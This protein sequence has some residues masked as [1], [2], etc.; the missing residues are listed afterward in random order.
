MQTVQYAVYMRLLEEK[1]PEKAGTC[2]HTV[3]THIHNTHAHIHTTHLA[4]TLTA[5]EIDE[6]QLADADVVTS[7]C[8]EYV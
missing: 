5:G 3:Y 7:V 6:I 1:L 4:L 2:K 8:V